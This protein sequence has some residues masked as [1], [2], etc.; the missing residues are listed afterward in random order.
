LE[1]IFMKNIDN[2]RQLFREVAV[3]TAQRIQ[4]RAAE[5]DAAGEFPRDLL[6]ALGKQGLL[7]ILIPEEYGGNGGD[8]TSFCMVI[9]EIA[10]V[11]GS[12]ALMIL[13]PGIMTS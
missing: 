8:I 1:K 4:P 3:K 9:E 7:S 11:C 5:I 13:S 12:S 2:E 6:D 10:K